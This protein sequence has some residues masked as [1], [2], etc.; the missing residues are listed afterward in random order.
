VSFIENKTSQKNK[1]KKYR[2]ERGVVCG[3]GEEE[4]ET[5]QG[6]ERGPQEKGTSK[7]S[8]LVLVKQVLWYQ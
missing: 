8:T 7:A 3:G 2:Q 4:P 5:A 1:L 6:R